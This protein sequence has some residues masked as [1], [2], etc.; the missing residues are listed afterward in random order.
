MLQD[1]ALIKY[2]KEG[3]RILQTQAF[4]SQEVKPLNDRTSIL[5]VRSQRDG[6]RL[7]IWAR[8]GGLLS[9]SGMVTEERPHGALQITSRR[10]RASAQLGA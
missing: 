7:E 1:G 9:S 5:K 4:A 3:K 6:E 10:D 8:A 2:R